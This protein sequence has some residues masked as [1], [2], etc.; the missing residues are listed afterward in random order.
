MAVNCSIFAL[1]GPPP[2]TVRSCTA[3]ASVTAVKHHNP[4]DTTRA[5]AA[6]DVLAQAAIAFLVSSSFFKLTNKG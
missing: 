1:A 5:E 3:P 6:N 4:S 2:V